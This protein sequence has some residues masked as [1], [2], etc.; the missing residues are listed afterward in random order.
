MSASNDGW[1][2]Y[3][4]SRLIKK[5]ESGFVVIKP[6]DDTGIVPW[7]CSVCGELYRTA[8]DETAHLKF[9]CCD[10]CALIFAYPNQ[11]SWKTGWRPERSK[12]LEDVVCRPFLR[13]RI[14]L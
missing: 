9:E 1:E 3:C 4:D 11:D 10:R 13:A 5:Y 14:K 8:D 7:S 12:V 2:V 6:I